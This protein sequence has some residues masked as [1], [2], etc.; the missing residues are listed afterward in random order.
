MTEEQF[1]QTFWHW[2]PEKN[3]PPNS[4]T[5]IKDIKPSDKLNLTITQTSFPASLQKELVSVWCEKLPQLQEVKYLWFTSR[6]NQEM[7][8][9]ACEMQSLEGLY[10]KWSVIKDIG[11]IANLK[12]IKRLH[13]GSSTKIEDVNPLADLVN[14]QVL[15]LIN[16]Q[17]IQDYSVIGNLTE[18]RELAITGDVWAPKHLKLNLY[19]RLEL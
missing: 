5:H 15:E 19:D 7:F 8:D 16:L 17:R 6:V 10:I 14:L 4:T 11:K 1:Y 13:I 3:W 12:N 9:A 18:L 2:S